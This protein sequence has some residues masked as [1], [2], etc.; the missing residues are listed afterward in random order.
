TDQR[1]ATVELTDE[2]ED[3]LFPFLWR[4]MSYEQPPDPEMR[5]GALFLRDEGIGG[6]LDTIVDEPVAALQPLDHLVADRLP[7]MRVDV[8]LQCPTHESQRRDRCAMSQARQVL[9]GLLRVDGQALQ[10]LDDEVH[11]VG[12]VALGSNPIQVPRPSSIITMKREQTLVD[13]RR[14]E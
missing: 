10:L 5:C 7:E 4:R 3:R 14:D 2:L 1:S 13:E 12:G 6:F 9:K 11:D 8:L